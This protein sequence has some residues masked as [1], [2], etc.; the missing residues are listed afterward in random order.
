[1]IGQR[2]DL[3]IHLFEIAA[4]ETILAAIEFPVG[5][6]RVARGI[7]ELGKIEIQRSLFYAQRQS[8]RDIL[9]LQTFL[10]R[11][12]RIRTGVTG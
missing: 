6:V 12:D 2:L 10:R 5:I 3:L 11:G 9:N 8:V 7:D 1:M 4:F